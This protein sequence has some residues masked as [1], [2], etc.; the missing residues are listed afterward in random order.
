MPRPRI[1]RWPFQRR[2]GA[3][4]IEA[5]AHLASIVESSEDAIISKD[6]NGII[7]SWNA[8]AERIFGYSAAEVVGQ[9]I[10]LLIP[11][12][13]QAEE[14][15]ILGRLRRGERV[16]HFETVRRARG[17]HEVPI[18]LT[19]SPIVDEKGQVV[20]ASKVARDIT[21]KKR[22]EDALAEQREWFETTLESIGDAVMA[23]DVR[24]EIIFMNAVAEHLTGWR[25]ED[26]RGKPC[27]TVFQ[28]VN[29]L[30]RNPG[31]NPVQ[32]ALDEGVVVGLA[33]HTLLIA[34]DGTERP[35]DDS[36]APIRNRDGRVVG[37]VLVF[38]DVTDR[39]QAE[40]ERGAALTE[41]GRL[42]EN[43]RLARADAERANRLKDEFVA[44]VSHE[45]RTP[46]NAMV[47]WLELLGKEDM[48][49]PTRRRAI[50][51]LRRNTKLQAQLVSDL[52]D[53]SRMLS[54]KLQLQL[55]SVD[56]ATVVLDATQMSE[57][58]A[59]AKGIRL[60]SHIEE[61]VGFAVGDPAR[62]QQIVS[63]LL[64]NA[65]KFTPRGG[66]VT[67]RLQRTD[68][69]AEIVVSDTGIG[70]DPTALPSIFDRF[71]QAD[72]STTRR[73]GGLGLGLAIVKQLTEMHGGS[74]TAESA[75]EGKGSRFIVSLRVD[76]AV[77][78][79][80]QRALEGD[81]AEALS[82]FSLEHVR[83]LLVED[84]PESLEVMQRLLEGQGAQVDAARDAHQALRLLAEAKPDVLVSDIGLPEMDGYRLIEHIR[85]LETAEGATIPAVA[86]TAFARAEDR[87]RA[88]RAGY[89][90]HLAKPVQPIELIAIVASLAGLGRRRRFSAP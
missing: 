16:A 29:E 73:F 7:Q 50:E 70:I 49:P 69:H 43:E 89:Q 66:E 61:G 4:H 77:R 63:N 31:K 15:E 41:R 5:R 62:L 47:G 58:A 87:A 82:T 48:D 67:I 22:A 45:L 80:D 27:G 17:G 36:A 37:V 1:L 44:M 72:A 53:T 83:V 65:L 52:L 32:R 90:A 39:R 3:T 74:V 10:T 33:N 81:Q 76:D 86:V 23:T 24:G 42:L 14:V 18:S 54:G 85:V 26:A 55:Q 38:R 34:A 35:I 13:R 40:A 9:S 20:G 75:G 88:L 19:I 8:A 2:T 57:A 11:P 6:L 60:R 84:E 79:A 25:R 68:S 64:S 28:I 51:V 56:L 71:R 21:D 59:Q 12:E 78:R 30:T 46:L